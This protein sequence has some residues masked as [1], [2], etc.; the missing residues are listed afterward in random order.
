VRALSVFAF[1]ALA[2]ASRA[3][4]PDGLADA[5]AARRLLG[6]GV[7]ARVVRIENGAGR[8]S[9]EY[10]PTT[11]ALV[12]ELSG[13]L[14]FYCDADGTQ[15]LSLRLGSAEADK[16]NPG[17]LFREICGGFGAWRWVDGEAGP[18]PGR[19][20]RLSND[21]FIECLAALR[22]RIALGAEPRAPRLLLYYVGSTPGRSGHAVLLFDGGRGLTAVDPDLPDRDVRIPAFVGG[23]P[24]SVARYIRQGDVESARVI[25]VAD[26]GGE[27]L[28]PNWAALHQAAGPGAGRPVPL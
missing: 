26:F 28:E 22:R 18:D 7:W 19:R 20:A 21:C 8:R 11:Y 27:R 17:P 15:S 1:L 9:A 12:F 6:P 14:W 2:A 16:L 25:P 4:M 10:P 5:L 24:R 3:R 23:D 13:I